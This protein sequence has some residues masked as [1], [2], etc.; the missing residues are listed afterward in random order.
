MRKRLICAVVLASSGLVMPHG[1]KEKPFFNDTKANGA[2]RGGAGGAQAHLYMMQPRLQLTGYHDTVGFVCTLQDE[3]P[4]TIEQFELSYVRYNS[5][6]TGPDEGP[7]GLI[8]RKSLRAFGFGGKTVKLNFTIGLPV[9]IDTPNYGLAIRMP[10][11]PNWPTDGL[12][13]VGQLNEPGDPKRPR[14]PAAHAQEVWAYE[15]LPGALQATPY[16]G[17][18]LDSLSM[19]G[20][21]AGSVLQGFVQSN[22][23]GG[24]SEQLWGPESMFPDASR[25]DSVGVFAHSNDPLF[26]FLLLYVSP[27]LNPTPWCCHGPPNDTWFLNFG[28][29][30]PFLLAALKLDLNGQATIGPFPLAG[31][32]AEMDELWMQGMVMSDAGQVQLTDAVGFAL[33]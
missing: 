11:A 9:K 31:F 7:T 18:A 4:S 32:P 19:T 23:Y 27:A 13:M 20:W 10:A 26:P 14:V 17:R 25:G 12:S 6:G 22:A 21:Y 1:A 3:D 2:T 16:A 15:R 8:L 30:F 29:P 5:S 28:R 24:A 33:K